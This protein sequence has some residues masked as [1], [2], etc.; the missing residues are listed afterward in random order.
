M[1]IEK[2]DR[3]IDIWIFA[4]LMLAVSIVCNW[5]GAARRMA[6]FVLVAPFL[7]G[8]AAF[9]FQIFIAQKPL[10]ELYSKGYPYRRLK[11]YGVLA[12]FFMFEF[13]LVW[14]LYTKKILLLKDDL[15][16]ITIISIGAVVFYHLFVRMKISL[17]FLLL[18][19]FVP[20]LAAGTALGLASYFHILEFI[21]PGKKIGDIVFFNT[22]Y[23]IISAVFFQV[24]CEEPA[25][26][27]YLMQRLLKKGEAFAII[28][29]SFAYALWRLPFNIFSGQGLYTTTLYFCGSFIVGAIFAI[30]FIKGR[31]LLVAIIC[32]GIIVGMSQSFFASS[33]HP[34]IRQ[35]MKFISPQAGTQV[36]ILLYACLLAGLILFILI[37]RKKLDAR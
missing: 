25:F 4:A 8:L 9:L 29:S 7:T 16:L 19:I 26:R 37:P 36:A 10:I 28:Y 12:S 30:L 6:A 20:L 22:V 35:Y 3:Y 31:N 1:D 18:G 32:H 34:G 11:A 15:F 21:V 33:A 2:K 23:W 5:L 24:L 27:G 14:G 13:V 17:R